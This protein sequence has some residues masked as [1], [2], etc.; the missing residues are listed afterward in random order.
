MLNARNVS[1]APVKVAV[2]QDTVRGRMD[3]KVVD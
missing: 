2:R 1:L 3:E